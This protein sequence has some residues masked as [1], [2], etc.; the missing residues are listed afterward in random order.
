MKSILFFFALL[1]LILSAMGVNPAQA[2]PMPATIWTMTDL[3]TLGGTQSV[4]TAI[5]DSG[6]V[7]GNADTAGGDT[8]AFVWDSLD[9]MT[10][11]GTLGGHY[12]E[13]IAINA[14]GQVAGWSHTAH[15]ETHAF[16]WDSLNGMTD[17][18]TL[19][20]NQ[21]NAIAIN[22]SG[23]VVGYSSTAGGQFHAF[24][25][26]SLNGMTDLGTLGGIESYA[27]A[28]NDSGQVV[29]RSYTAGGETH[30]FV[31]DSL[32]GMTDLGTLG[33]NTGSANAINNSGQVVGYSSTAGGQF[34]AFVWDSLNGMT[35]LST[36]G[37]NSKAVAIN[38]S[39]QVVGWSYTSGNAEKHAFI[40][41]PKSSTFADVPIDSFAWAQIEAIYNAGI[42]GGCSTNPLNY[43]PNNSVT[44]AQMA[45][46][47]LRGIHGSSYSPPTATGTVFTDVPSD[48]F[49]AAWI[50]QM[51]AEGITSGCGN[52]NY[53]PNSTVTRAQMAV[54]LLRAK[55]GAAYSPPAATGTVFTDVPSNGFAAAWIEQLVTEGVTS[56]C[57]G[58]NY[59]P[60]N[61][62]TRAQM[63]VFLQR[64]FNLPLQ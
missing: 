26:D 51:V 19:G 55:Y 1:A 64:T 33:G 7:V 43:C 12:S 63:A 36:L 25:W 3:G 37:G 48:A 59:C 34:H 46:F 8:H 54:F 47:L 40:T 53:C 17:L 6:Q 4:A 30:A 20:G 60:N 44:R 39:G 32:D 5:N 49:A 16:V 18:G 28:I 58:G 57:G 56:G 2:A 23:Q 24:V 10:D 29:G 21:S 22:A 42:T 15:G 38:A 14:S 13:A 31:W 52:G 11:L 62:V 61:A 9:G 35:D 45:V 27:V 50:E 41:S